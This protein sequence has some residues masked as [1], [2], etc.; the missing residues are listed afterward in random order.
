M[1]TRA[2]AVQVDTTQAALPNYYGHGEYI[3]NGLASTAHTV[4]ITRVSGT[5]CI[6]GAV[7]V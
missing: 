4:T 3:A 5:P 7:G 2:E 6:V 1:L